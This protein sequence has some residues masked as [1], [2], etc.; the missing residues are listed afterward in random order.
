M[1]ELLNRPLIKSQVRQMLS[2]AQVSPRA[3]AALYLVLANAVSLVGSLGAGA[4]LFSTFLSIFSE[5]LSAVLV[6]GFVLYCMAVRRGER[7]EYLSIFDGFSFAGKIIGLNILL[8]LFVFLWSCLFVIPGI[9]AAYRYRFALYNLYENPQ[10]NP[11]EAL[12]M[13]KRQTYGYKAQLLTLDLS[14][15][16][17]MLL[18]MLPTLPTVYQMYLNYA[19]GDPAFFLVGMPLWQAVLSTIWSIGVTILYLPN[20]QCVELEYFEAAKRTSGVSPLPDQQAGSFWGGPDNMG[21][22]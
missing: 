4:G 16:G 20:Y 9:V 8:Y 13:S 10:L 7:A 18:A 5:L 3:M 6:A 1:A 2:T 22:Y 17:W 19:A 21:G 14:Y 12:E 15:L 11:L